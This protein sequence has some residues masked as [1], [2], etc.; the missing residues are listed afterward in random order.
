MIELNWN[1]EEF[2]CFLLLYVSHVDIDYS[3]EEKAAIQSRV[4]QKTYDEIYA[5]CIGMSDF[6]A[7]QTMISY[8]GVYFPTIEQKMELIATI[9]KQFFADG[10]YAYVEK[11]V[12]FFLD[13][14]L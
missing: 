9:K 1:Y 5:S 4:D 10:E 11:E 13:K 14:M 8:K 6:Q 3:E 12:L 2:V 7:L